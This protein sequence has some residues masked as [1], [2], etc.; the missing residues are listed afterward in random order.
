MAG[1]LGLQ[2]CLSGIEEQPQATED[3]IQGTNW[4]TGLLLQEGT[5]RDLARI[6]LEGI[7]SGRCG[8][9]NVSL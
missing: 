8:Q 3:P 6:P 2:L 7:C 1:R 4:V 5:W 9:S